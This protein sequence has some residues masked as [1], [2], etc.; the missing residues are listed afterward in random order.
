MLLLLVMFE[1]GCYTGLHVSSVEILTLL[2]YGSEIV[3]FSVVAE[4]E[5]VV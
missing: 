4:S 3:L 1:L 5:A 2:S